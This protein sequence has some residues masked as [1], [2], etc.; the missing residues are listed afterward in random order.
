MLGTGVQVVLTMAGCLAGAGVVDRVGG[1]I[2][3]ALLANPLS[4]F[5]ALHVVLLLVSPTLFDR[6]LIVLMP[7]ALAFTAVRPPRIRWGAGIGVLALF[8]ACSVGL[9]HDWLAW[10]SARWELGRSPLARGIAADDIEGGLEWDSWHAPGQVASDRPV[11]PP[12]GLTLRFNHFRHLSHHRPIRTILLAG[13]RRGR[14]RFPV[15][16]PCGLSPVHGN[17]CFFIRAGVGRQTKLK[18][19]FQFDGRARRPQR[20]GRR[21]RAR[22]ERASTRCRRPDPSIEIRLWWLP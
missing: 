2:S 19:G 16:I 8:A 3:K 4:L 14:P 12:S 21:A 20:T 11:Y 22:E 10:N 7:G 6:Y 9:M 18:M 1:R 15:L 17:S 13:P 5:T